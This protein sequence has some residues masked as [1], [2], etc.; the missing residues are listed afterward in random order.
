[1]FG[2]RREVVSGEEA[3]EQLRRGVNILS[4]TVACSLGPKGR[5]VICQRVYNKSRNTKDGV[6]IA[7]EFFLKHPVE[8][9]GAQLIK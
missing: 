4:D 3:R 7:S 8:D 5:N 6:T 9:I 2:D 1:M